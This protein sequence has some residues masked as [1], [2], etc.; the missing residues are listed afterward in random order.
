MSQQPPNILDTIRNANTQSGQF[1]V[2]AI[3]AGLVTSAA[4]STIVFIL[5]SVLRPRHKIVYAPKLK[6]ASEKKAPPPI[7]DGVFSWLKPVWKYGDNTLIEKIG[8]DAV[9]FLRF[10]RMCRNIFICLGIGSCAIIP[11]NIIVGLKSAGGQANV[12]QNKYP[13][14]SK[15]A[16]LVHS[17]YSRLKASRKVTCGCKSCSPGFTLASSYS[18]CI[19][20]TSASSSC[21][22]SSFC[23]WN[24]KAP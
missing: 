6:Y 20:D 24:T 4:I 18:G 3:I 10:W 23:Q 7:D 5:F 17:V 19:E 16:D 1:G 12:A 14:G 13:K 2:T 15:F 9:V 22:V 8:M 21:G 11:F